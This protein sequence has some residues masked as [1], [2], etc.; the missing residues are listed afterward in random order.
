MKKIILSLVFVLVTGTSFMYASSF[1][2]EF[3]KSLKE[4]NNTVDDCFDEAW[5]FGTEEGGGDET[6]EW[7]MMDRYYVMWCM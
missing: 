5:E 6:K 4:T 7:E 2:E 3:V 1:N